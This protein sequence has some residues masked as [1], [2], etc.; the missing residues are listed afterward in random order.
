MHLYELFY[1]K[2]HLPDV[3]YHISWQ[4]NRKGIMSKGLLPRIKEFPELERKAGVYLFETISQAEDWALY[5]G[6]ASVKA[7][8]I[9]IWEVI[10][11]KSIQIQS[12]KTDM[13]D[14]YDSWIVYEPIPPQNIHL[15]KTI[16]PSIFKDLSWYD[17]PN[18]KVKRN[19]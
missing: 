8:N 4:K 6:N 17:T 5:F 1:E 2:I 18:L 12:D 7:G 13:N 11:P 3:M 15:L 14:V 16:T 10:L 9:D 19:S